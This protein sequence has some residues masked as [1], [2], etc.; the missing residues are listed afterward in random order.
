MEKVLVGKLGLVSNF[1]LIEKKSSNLLFR[2]AEHTVKQ[3]GEEQEDEEGVFIRR[4]ECRDIYEGMEVI[5][6]IYGFSSIEPNTILMGWASNTKEPLK[7]AH[8]IKTFNELDYNSLF[9]H[10][11]EEEGFRDR[12]RIDIRWR[13]AGNNFSLAL[14]LVRFITTNEDWRDAEIRLLTIKNDF[15][16][17][18]ILENEATRLMR[19]FRIDATIKIIDNTSGN[20]TSAEIFKEESPTADLSVFGIPPIDEN[21]AHDYIKNIN[22]LLDDVGT[23]LLVNASSYFEEIKSAEEE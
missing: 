9:F 18:R 14:T 23:T 21:N 15:S 20:K 22:K 12:K 2:K 10:Y 5:A 13:G 16:S 7:F 1:G 19:T 8:L 4:H 6:S 11:N 3:E 17:S